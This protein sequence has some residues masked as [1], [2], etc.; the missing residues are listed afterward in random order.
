[1]TSIPPSVSTLLTRAIGRVRRLRLLRGLATVGIAVLAGIFAVMA[2]DARF[3][4]FDD[5]LRYAMTTG[6]ALLAAVT[7]YLAVVRPL[8]RRLDFRTM[9]KA[10]DARHPEQDERLSTLVE[11][12]E[13]G[14]GSA[15]FSA[16]L[17]ALVGRLAE[18]DVAKIDPAQDFPARPALRRLVVF[19]LMLLAL[20]A[21]TAVSPNLIGRLLVRA[22]A[23]WV[24]VGNLFADE[25]VVTPGD[26]VALSGDVIRIQA[27]AQRPSSFSIRISRRR[28]ALWTEETPEPMADGVYETTA[29]MSE[30]EW[31]YRVKAGHAVTRY[32]HVRVSE[33]PKYE[34]LVARVTYPDYT[35]FAPVAYSNADVAAIRAIEGSR[36]SFDLKV[37]ER[38]TVADFR[39]GGEPLFEHTMVSNLTTSWSLELVNRDGFRS[40]MGVHP[41]VS[42]RDEPPTLVIERPNNK[43]PPL[44]PHAKIPLELT[45][46]DDVRVHRPVVWRSVDG[47]EAVVFHEVEKF[48]SAGGRLWRGETE[49][50][51]STLDLADARGIRFFVV[52]ADNCPPEYGGPHVVTSSVIS[53]TLAAR[54][55][56]LEIADLKAQTQKANALVGEAKRRL[57][58]AELLTRQLK[59][60][61]KCD[62]K[63]SEATEKKNERAAH[64]TAEAKKRI[65]E[66]RDRFKKDERF[67]PLVDPLES[68]LVGKL[69]PAL[70]KIENAPF[71]ERNER[72]EEMAAATDELRAAQ[73]QVEDL[74]RQLKERSERLDAYERTKDLAERQA[75]L[76]RSAQELLGER[77]A[78]LERLEAWKRLEEEAMRRA[79]ELMRQ[80]P[81]A[82]LAEARRKM[83]TA[84]RKI[85]E[86]RAAQQEQ[87]TL[88]SQREQQEQRT[89]AQL[90]QQEAARQ[91]ALEQ[92]GREQR[93][94]EEAISRKDARTAEDAQRKA[95]DSLARA[96]ATPGVRAMQRLAAETYRKNPGEAAQEAQRAAS[97]ARQAEQEIRKGIREGTKTQADLDALDNELRKRLREK[98]SENADLRKQA[99]ERLRRDAVTAGAKAIE[100]TAADAVNEARKH[101]RAQDLAELAEKAVAASQAARAE[102]RGVRDAMRRGEKTAADL[103]A[104]DRGFQELAKAKA[105]ELANAVAEATR[106][107]RAAA[108]RAA[109]QAP[110]LREAVQQQAQ[111]RQAIQAAA[112][113]REDERRCAAANNR[114]AAAAKAREAER[115]EAQAFAAQ[116]AAED[117]LERAEASDAVKAMQ[118]QA[119]DFERDARTARHTSDKTAAALKAQ[120]EASAAL[121]R[122]QALREQVRSG[123]KPEAD[124]AALEEELARKME[125]GPSPDRRAKG[126]GDAAEA[127]DASAEAMS[128]GVKA[129]AEALGLSG[130]Q[131]PSQAQ[132]SAGGGGVQSEVDSLARELKRSDSPDF[133]KKLF[134]RMGWFKIRDISKDGP[135]AVD[136]KDVPREYRDLVRRY[137]LKLAEESKPDDMRR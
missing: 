98:L 15:G 11:L 121:K 38:E 123:A 91:Q 125:E 89:R 118:R 93:R 14:A 71:R 82:E 73:K 35:G 81:S 5:R 48:A 19:A 25:I 92:A 107:E 34:S 135:S 136:L 24:D 52:A 28:G 114:P 36:V 60:E 101:P 69:A 112:A 32:Y 96:A 130:A 90:A 27:R 23:P 104:L 119:S 41:L 100:K 106:R 115:F 42:E 37:A 122:E 79:D 111:A 83:E 51:L 70:E 3:V 43:L 57:R 22:V 77:P 110:L 74:S 131:A 7:G 95:E 127:A 62:G 97:A 76:A 40:S 124:L 55:W 46:S 50:D 87:R 31:R 59:D 18:N 109:R 128:R 2:L 68:I 108:D 16:S 21:G 120:D 133:F 1:M 26:V 33:R 49:L 134:A 78:D 75:A 85:A 126:T 47:G 17:F 56:G 12:S 137:F 129:Q 99:E 88:R 63:V 105:E 54:E 65:E 66:L 132:E 39:I 84:V 45:A 117:C 8:R 13:A 20:V 58:D 67:A 72:A 44:P 53:V 94:A 64:E 116:Q 80:K 61:L 103:E 29:D 4:I 9:A 30:R 10:L 6:I 102:E 86:L 113:R